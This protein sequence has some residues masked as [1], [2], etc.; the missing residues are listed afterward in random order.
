M[1]CRNLKKQVENAAGS[2]EW[3]AIV[4][5]REMKA[6]KVTLRNLKTG[7]EELLSIEDAAR[8]IMG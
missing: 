5:E 3:I 2:C 6:A 4:G 1:N 8:K 7:K